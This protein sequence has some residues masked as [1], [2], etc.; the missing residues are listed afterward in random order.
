M[1]Y[2]DDCSAEINC[3]IQE[4]EGKQGPFF[5]VATDTQ[6]SFWSHPADAEP[7]FCYLFA[8]SLYCIHTNA[9]SSRSFLGFP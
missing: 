6:K 5:S 1:L 4:V 3:V 8:N 9:N 2:M 7:L